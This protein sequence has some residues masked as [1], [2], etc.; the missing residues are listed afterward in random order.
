[1]I[2]TFPLCFKHILYNDT[3]AHPAEILYLC[4]LWVEW[5]AHWLKSPGCELDPGMNAVGSSAPALAHGGYP[6]LACCFL[7]GSSACLSA[8]WPL[9]IRSPKLCFNIIVNWLF[10]FALQR[11]ICNRV[12]IY[13]VF[14][15]PCSALFFSLSWL[16]KAVSP[17]PAWILAHKS[18]L[19][20][21]SWLTISLLF[22]SRAS[23]FC[24]FWSLSPIWRSTCSR[25]F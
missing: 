11:N 8:V 4:C 13:D 21:S 25:S 9:N 17:S 20:A 1:M 3:P 16:S 22:C 10:T 2:Y 12:Y 18:S 24:I 14:T 6:G 19:S 15:C 7:T 5:W 23:R